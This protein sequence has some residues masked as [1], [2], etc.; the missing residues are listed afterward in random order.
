MTGEPLGI[1]GDSAGNIFVTAF[2]HNSIDVYAAGSTTPTSSLV[3][4]GLTAIYYIAMDHNGNL[5][6]DGW[7]PG[8][9]GSGLQIDEFPVGSQTAHKLIT[10]TGKFPGG[11]A[12]NSLGTLYVADEGNGSNGVILTLKPPYNKVARTFSYNGLITGIDLDRLEKHIWAAN[13]N[14]GGADVAQEYSLSGSLLFTTTALPAGI[15]SYGI[16]KKK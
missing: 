1:T 16:A 7:G 2:P 13:L 11:M 5:F 12:V 6:A 8:G 3:D 4:I 9:P 15:Y 14:A 10:I